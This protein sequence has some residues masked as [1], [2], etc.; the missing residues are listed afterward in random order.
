MG[1]DLVFSL[2][3]QVVGRVRDRGLPADVCRHRTAGRR[4]DSSSGVQPLDEGGRRQPMATG[5]SVLGANHIKQEPGKRTRR[6]EGVVGGGGNRHCPDGACVPGVLPSGA[7]HA[8]VRHHPLISVI[9]KR[10]GAEEVGNDLLIV[11]RNNVACGVKRIQAKSEPRG[12]DL[13]GFGHGTQMY[14]WVPTA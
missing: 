3:E 13:A 7:N 8:T 1:V 11:V 10:V 9:L 14:S 2:V 5:W 12:H 4:R 6:D